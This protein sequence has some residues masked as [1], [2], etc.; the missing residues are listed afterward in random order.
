[1]NNLPTS[2]TH[3][4]LPH[5]LAALIHHVELSKAGWHKYA[6]RHLLLTSLNNSPAGASADQI[7]A[8]A[9]TGLPS[10]LIRSEVH[11]LLQSM[12]E[13][14]RIIEL[15]DG[16]FKLAEQAR[17][18][19]ADQLAEAETRTNEVRR[20]FRHVCASL[21][22][23][24]TLSWGTFLNDFLEPLVH[25]LGAKTHYIV[26]GE[27]IDIGETNTSYHFLSRFPD[28][29]RATILKKITRF[30]DPRSE[31]VRHYV[32]GL[33]NTA[34]IM[35]AL[36]LP[37]GTTQRILERMQRT[38]RLRV[39]ADTNFLFHLLGLDA[40][41]DDDTVHQLH[42]ILRQLPRR[43]KVKIYMLSCT[44]TEA[45]HTLHHYRDTL[46]YTHRS[47]RLM[48][49]IRDASTT[50][51]GIAGTY[52]RK[53][54]VNNNQIV[55]AKSY[56]GPYIDNFTEIAR[57]KN[58][59]LYDSPEA[60]LS[61]DQEVIDDLQDQL[62]FQRRV[63]TRRQ[64]SYKTLMHDMVLWHFAKRLRRNHIESPLDAEVWLATIDNSLLRFDV[65]KRN[66]EDNT[67]PV[68]IHP[69]VLLQMLQFWIPHNEALDTALM[70][71]LRPMQ[72]FDPK[73]EKTTIK[74]I[75]ALARFEHIDDVPR[76]T[77]AK[78][79]VSD[80]VRGKIETATDDNEALE[81]VQSEIAEQNRLLADQVREYRQTAEEVRTAVEESRRS[82]DVITE[83]RDAAEALL[84]SERAARQ[85][86]ESEL[87]RVA[88]ERAKTA[89]EN[90][91]REEA[92]RRVRRAL[93]RSGETFVT[94]VV[95]SL[96]GVMIA[97]GTRGLSNAYLFSGISSSMII[98][99]WCGAYVLRRH[100]MQHATTK[101]HSWA[102]HALSVMKWCGGIVAAIVA[103]V[104]VTTLTGAIE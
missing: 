70:N 25:E 46:S 11:S 29:D 10:P 6:L 15:P 26:T 45:T 72:R 35:H 42:E 9:S 82:L 18:E 19:L 57:S 65:Y 98:S 56:F 4:T 44:V 40:T 76:D 90:A 74:I 58:I 43:I 93:Y 55:S 80:L 33:L 24:I 102:K 71:S 21:R 31:A 16:H 75:R 61:M 38:L 1:M 5:D 96:A 13:D 62:N 69:T 78:V 68:C 92:G 59:E 34:F 63:P 30:L 81:I 20:H 79:L 7:H 67:L 17:R 84:E 89:R 60:E 47:P 85:S 28:K 53:A 49:T 104:I 3:R 101:G 87:E 41:T 91:T 94:V 23:N 51:S 50:L 73:A 27:A 97:H 2:P 48:N 37:A 52:F 86:L 100:L 99:V 77:M 103:G 39:F 95:L 88:S 32:L 22:D 64:K 83:E 14:G 36:T 12:K 66:R 8:A 54:T